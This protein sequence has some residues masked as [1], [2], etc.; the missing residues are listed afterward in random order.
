MGFGNYTSNISSYFTIPAEN[1]DR[2]SSLSRHSKGEEQNGKKKS[3]K[4]SASKGQTLISVC[5]RH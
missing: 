2:I 4:Q 3:A 1:H 5:G